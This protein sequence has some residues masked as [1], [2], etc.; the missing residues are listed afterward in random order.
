MTGLNTE[1][2]REVDRITL[3]RI[4]AVTGEGVEDDPVRITTLWI[5]DEGEV[6]SYID[7]CGDGPKDQ[8]A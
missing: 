2:V 1:P 6:I 4:R 8:E 3:T 7:P 5:T